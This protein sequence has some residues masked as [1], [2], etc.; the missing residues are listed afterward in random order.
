MPEPLQKELAKQE[1]QAVKRKAEAYL[2]GLL[3]P[4]EAD[5]KVLSAAAAKLKTDAA[6]DAARRKKFQE[7]TTATKLKTFE[8]TETV[9][10]LGNEIPA[11]S[12]LFCRRQSYR[13]CQMDQEAG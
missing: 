1:S 6:N 13:G 12:S 8:D 10:C 3:L 4:T 2:D 7:V 9:H 5:G 11:V